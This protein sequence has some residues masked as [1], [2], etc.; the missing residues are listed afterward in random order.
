MDSAGCWPLLLLAAMTELQVRPPPRGD[1]RPRR[2]VWWCLGHLCRQLSALVGF[3]RACGNACQPAVSP[4]RMTRTPTANASPVALA[5]PSPRALVEMA[6]FAY[7]QHH[8]ARLR[9]R[10]RQPTSHPQSC[11]L[12]RSTHPTAMRTHLS[13]TSYVGR[14]HYDTITDVERQPTPP[15]G[16]PAQPNNP[17]S[18]YIDSVPFGAAL[19]TTL[20]TSPPS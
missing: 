6:I 18:Y 12:R 3:G 7:T 10:N 17:H 1:G 8:R 16:S 20:A 13:H 15:G 9:T 5:A 14:A 2:G 4:P 19:R 11:E